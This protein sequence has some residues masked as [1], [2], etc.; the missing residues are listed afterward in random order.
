M[1][2]LAMVLGF[3]LLSVEVARKKLPLSKNDI[4]NLVLF[5]VVA[6]I[7]GPRLYYVIFRWD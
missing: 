3:Y 2:I 5:T 1:Y 6:G 4:L 7:L